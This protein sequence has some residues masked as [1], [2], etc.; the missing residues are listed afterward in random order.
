M[1]FVDV[2]D[3]FYHI[4]EYVAWCFKDADGNEGQPMRTFDAS[5]GLERL[6]DPQTANVQIAEPSLVIQEPVHM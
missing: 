1:N 3:Y 6:M 2:C 4:Q 5:I